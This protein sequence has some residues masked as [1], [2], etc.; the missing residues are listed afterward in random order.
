MIKKCIGCGSVLQDKE[1]H[2]LGYTPNMKNDYCK[3][4]FRLK[5]YG[6]EKE[7]EKVDE[8]KI[9]LKV[10][11]SQGVVFFFI[12]Y[13]NI[14][15][16]TL[17][18]FKSIQ[19]TKVLVISKCDTLRRDMKFQK[20][21]KWLK[22]VYHI[23]EEVLFVSNKNDF[24]NVNIFKYMDKLDCKRGFIMGITNAGKSTF[25]NHILKKHH[26][27][28]EIVTSKKANT[29]LDFIQ[30]RVDDYILYDT[31]GFDYLSLNKRIIQK[32]IKPIN[33]QIKKETTIIIDGVVELYFDK[34]NSV[35]IYTT[36]YCVKRV[37]KNIIRDFH[38]IEVGDNQD[39]IIPG[40]GFVNVKKG[41]RVLANIEIK[42]VRKSISGEDYE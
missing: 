2:C 23:E 22:Q 27:K 36:D 29:T 1:E 20:I 33:I 9:I 41:C 34:E 17:D 13:L 19:L 3:R 37:F 42:E 7:G 32:E 4:C 5:Y 14:N 28:K 21:K 26:I 40:Y 16:Y 35:T 11:K 25:I 39:L 30:L 6:E 10:N 38:E 31:P 18:I 15:K 8:S 24:K 12:D